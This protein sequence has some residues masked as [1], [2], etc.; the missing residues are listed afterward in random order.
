MGKVAKKIRLLSLDTSSEDTGWCIFL[1]GKT[2]PKRYGHIKIKK[3]K[4]TNAVYEMGK[5]INKLILKEKPD[6]LILEDLNVMKSVKTAK[7]LSEIIGI[8]IGSGLSENEDLFYDKLPPSHWRKLIAN[9]YADGIY[10]KKREICK[11][12]DIDMVKSIYNIDIDND[13]IADAILVGLAY[14]LEFD[15]D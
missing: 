6:I 10:P 4:G 13:N 11:Q 7:V 8:A 3:K 5:E 9:K 1:D 12:W 15:S 14:I 2:K